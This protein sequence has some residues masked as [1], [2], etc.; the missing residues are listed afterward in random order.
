MCRYMYMCICMGAN[1]QYLIILSVAHKLLVS[2]IHNK[3]KGVQ[4][5]LELSS[6]CTYKD[7]NHM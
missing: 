1:S 2:H 3:H 4:V 5:Q 6:Y 7:T